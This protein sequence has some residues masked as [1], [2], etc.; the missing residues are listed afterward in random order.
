MLSDLIAKPA[1]CAGLS[2]SDN[3]VRRIAHETVAKADDAKGSDQSNLP[4]LAFVL[5]QLFEQRSN[6]E[7]SE[8]VYAQLDGIKG[9]IARHAATVE[10]TIREKQG[11]TTAALLPKLFQ[12]L[13]IVNAEGL[14]TRRRPLS[15]A[16]SSEMKEVIHVLVRERLLHTEGE[17]KSATVSISHEALFEAWPSLRA[18]VATNRK[19]LMDQTLLESRARKWQ[20]MGKPWF[21]GLAS[22]REYRDFRRAGMAATPLT[23]EYLDAS[24]QAKCIQANLLGTLILLLGGTNTWLWREGLTLEDGVLTAQSTFMS[25]HIEPKKQPISAGTFQQGDTHEKGNKTEQPVRKVS[26][27]PFTIGKFEVTFEEY[28]RFAFATNRRPLP[29]DETWGRGR[30]PVI[31]ISWKDAKAYAQWLSQQTGK[32]YRLPTEAEWEYAARSIAKNKDD[33]WAGTSNES[34]LKDYAV[35]TTDRTE[36]VGEKE[37][38]GVGLYDMSGNAYEWVEDCW[39]E[40]YEGAPP[41]GSAWLETGGGSCDRRVL[42]GGSWLNEP[43]AL[44]SSDRGRDLD[45]YR[46]KDVGFRLAQDID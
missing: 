35:F 6:H 2:I 43:N 5:N 40:N 32:R 12:S 17:G 21:S 29:K 11:A 36:P 24:R 1:R 26:I 45:V 9:A 46:N 34:Q 13:V 30:R 18:Y 7:L 8:T 42:R 19:Q 4:L 14:P 23:K 22:G 41:D 38:N 20:E 15:S 39:H 27:K 44:R 37:P 25:I 16:F 3:L 31:N 10:T 33:V 28:K